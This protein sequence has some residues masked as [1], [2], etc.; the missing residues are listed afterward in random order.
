MRFT[1]NRAQATGPAQ[2][3]RVADDPGRICGGPDIADQ[4]QSVV[5]AS[6]QAP[7]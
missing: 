1:A 7:A 2:R 6:K 5:M 4:S 3:L